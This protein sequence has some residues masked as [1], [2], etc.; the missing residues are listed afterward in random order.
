MVMIWVSQLDVL[1]V[2]F[3]FSYFIL[4]FGVSYFRLY[5]VFNRILIMYLLL[6]LLFLFIFI[7]HVFIFIIII[8]IIIVFFCPFDWA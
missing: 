7:Y 2:N 6:S 1:L 4:L 3:F 5:F 8:I